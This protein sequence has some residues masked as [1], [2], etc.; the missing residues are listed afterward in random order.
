ML[1]KQHTV[2]LDVGLEHRR[3]KQ[4][5]LLGRLDGDNALRLTAISLEDE[6]ACPWFWLNYNGDHKT[7]KH[8]AP[9]EHPEICI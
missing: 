4:P 2:D 1:R 9:W 5:G 6:C 3:Q 7:S 8:Q